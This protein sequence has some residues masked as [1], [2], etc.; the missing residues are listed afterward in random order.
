MSTEAVGIY[1]RVL[2]EVRD[3][4]RIPLA[5]ELGIDSQ[6]I[7]RLEKGMATPLSSFLFVLNQALQGNLDQVNELFLDPEATEDTARQY[8]L[9]W[10]AQRRF[11]EADLARWDQLFAQIQDDPHKLELL[12]RYAER[13]RDEEPTS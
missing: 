7:E 5:Q 10:A 11:Q 9:A 6:Q 1:M 3:I 8:A 4:G 13:L 12:I 2:R